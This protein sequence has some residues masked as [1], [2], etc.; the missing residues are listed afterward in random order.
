[1]NKKILSV[2]VLV[3][4]IVTVV[5]IS[6]VNLTSAQM[7]DNTGVT[8][9][10][11]A[12]ERIL[13]RVDALIGVQ[14]DE[15]A[16]VSVGAV[17]GPDVYDQVRFHNSVTFNPV[18]NATTTTGTAATLVQSDLTNTQYHQVTFG[19]A[20]NT[21][22]TYT[23]PATSTLTNFVPVVGSRTEVCWFNVASSTSVHDL[24]FAAGTGWDLA[25][26]STT[27][28]AAPPLNLKEDNLLCIEAVRQGRSG[29]STTVT[30]D[31]TGIIKSYHDAD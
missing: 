8:I 9:S 17:V 22:F 1:M 28:T 13:K 26:A 18:A 6:V 15:P 4:A 14:V 2:A 7:P 23:L 29:S 5:G 27:E 10:D 30:G 12:L 21:D 24:V 31:I 20:V 16:P 19:G 3:I 25:V 11:N